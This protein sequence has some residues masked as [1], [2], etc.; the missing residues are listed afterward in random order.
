MDVLPG[1]I[2]FGAGLLASIAVQAV[3]RL[4]QRTRAGALQ[5]PP[6]ST[7]PARIAPAPIPAQPRPIPPQP[8]QSRP[9]EPSP[10]GARNGAEQAAV[11]ALLK[12][13]ERLEVL[14][15]ELKK[16]VEEADALIDLTPI[17]IAVAEDPQGRTLHLNR[18]LRSLLGL[19]SEPDLGLTPA[20][21]RLRLR[22]RRDGKEIPADEAPLYKCLATG[23]TVVGEQFELHQPNGEARM[24]LNSARPLFSPTGEVSGCVSVYTDVTEQLRTA[25]AL[26][27]SEERFR[28]AFEDSPIGV[29]RAAADGRIVMANSTALKMVGCKSAEEFVQRVPDA[30]EAMSSSRRD[31]PITSE[32]SWQLP[33]G[34]IV[35]IRENVRQVR[36]ANGNI[37]C[38][39]GTLEDVS[40]RRQA[41]EQ[42]RERE[43]LFR[44]IIAAIPCG[45]FWKD[46]HSN[47]L[48]CN[49]QFA[50]HQGLDS[51]EQI[52]GRR[53]H[54][55]PFGSFAGEE[56]Q[57]ADHQIIE[58]GQPI[59]NLEETQNRPNGKA[60]LLISRVPL[61]NHAGDVIG[62]LG[63]CLDLTEQKRLEEQFRQAQKMEAVGRLA[64]GI[65]HDFNNL[66]TVISGN[67]DLMHQLPPDAPA[68]SQRLD[69][70]RD[71]AFRAAGLVR[72]LL[73]FSRRQSSRPEMLNLNEVISALTGMLRRF[74]SEKIRIATDLAPEAVRIRA[75]RVQL[76][77]VVMNL[78][79]NAR[80]AMPGGGVLT[81]TTRTSS[82]MDPA[83]PDVMHLAHLSV[84]D[85][86]C[87][88]SEAVKAKIFEP[89]FTTKGPEMGTGLGLATVHGIVYQ[90]GGRIEV[91]SAMGVGTTF[92]IEF[93]AVLAAPTASAEICISRRTLGESVGRGRSVLLVEDED[94]VRT[95]TRITLESQGYHVTEAA[96][97]ETALSLLD[98]S[99]PLD[100]LVTDLT[101]PGMD[102]QELAATVRGDR[103][104]LGV[105][106][107]SGYVPES[108][109]LDRLT[110]AIFLPKPFSPLQLLEAA[111]RLVTRT[112][113]TNDPATA[114]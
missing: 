84:S 61:R 107:M 103:P 48:G 59:L 82:R 102:G 58:T 85:T 89:F 56:S 76:E 29:Y 78:V 21:T 87:G 63:T 105:V 42:L 100:L 11:A 65:A 98:P 39:E 90:S 16:R 111:G 24:I 43:S 73:T 57:A 104:N 37:L 47:Y 9:G 32:F 108:E 46:R 109:H 20:P 1:A 33:S 41:E 28:R 52:V 69:D 62:V 3:L 67:A 27:E 110:R 17:G 22:F 71:A 14:N 38:Y 8:P 25:S 93:P 97:A 74:L 68:F 10:G 49:D 79:V 19:P 34:A 7:P 40:E 114:S 26:R 96:D 2:V 83:R 112:D 92:H 80:D 106:F 75:D 86:G 53:D 77:Q 15:K 113:A 101:M 94:A 36:D 44:N 18:A 6:P 88:M 45:V 55:L 66:L 5:Q 13:K 4:G 30:L 70:V 60:T 95:L 35:S 72:Q 23:Q 64:G 99:R 12:E 54:E 91:E 51:A 50:R 31:V 81:L